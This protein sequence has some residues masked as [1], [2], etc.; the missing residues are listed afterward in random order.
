MSPASATPNRDY[1]NEKLGI[2][3]KIA[4]L[5]VFKFMP[6]QASFRKGVFLPEGHLLM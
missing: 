3:N 6:L 4:S 5:S 1:R 2:E